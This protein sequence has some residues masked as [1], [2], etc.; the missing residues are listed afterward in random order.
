MFKEV[1]LLLKIIFPYS[2][3]HCIF[4]PS[5]YNLAYSSLLFFSIWSLNYNILIIMEFQTETKFT[6]LYSSFV[7]LSSDKMLENFQYC[8]PYFLYNVLKS[9]F[10]LHCSLFVG[11]HLISK[12]ISPFW[13]ASINSRST[14]ISC[15][16]S[17]VIRDWYFK[18]PTHWTYHQQHEL[19]LPLYFFS[20]V[21]SVRIFPIM[22][23]WNFTTQ[24]APVSPICHQV[25]VL[26]VQCLLNPFHVYCHL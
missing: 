26:D 13:N 5:F 21:N 19:G 20:F 1:W 12:S 2:L 14:F 10:Q 6:F 22:E 17:I 24:L 8:L 16:M 11:G 4:C 15:I 23:S 18:F 3:W 25:Q 7:Y 9:L